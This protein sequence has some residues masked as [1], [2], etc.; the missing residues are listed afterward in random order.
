[1]GIGAPLVRRELGQAAAAFPG[2]VQ[3]P[4]H[5]R[6]ADA[7]PAQIAANVH[8]LDGHPLGAT[9]AECRD[10]RQLTRTDHGAVVVGDDEL[11]ARVGVDGLE[12]GPHRGVV[13]LRD[14]ALATPAD[15][16]TVQ[17]FEHGRHIR[18]RGD[19]K[20]Q[21]VGIVPRADHRPPLARGATD[22]RW[23]AGS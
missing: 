11:V 2:P 3:R 6:P 21:H 9:P 20:G 8:G 1:V 18:P 7:P 17:Q 19:P 16:V 13:T 4:H 23:V 5:H 12:R 14:E 10:E 15:R 22:R